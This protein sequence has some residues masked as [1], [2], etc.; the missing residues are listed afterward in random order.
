LKNATPVGRIFYETLAT[1]GPVQFFVNPIGFYPSL[2]HFFVKRIKVYPNRIN[3]LPGRIEFYPN[4]IG[5]FTNRIES[6]NQ[7]PEF[8]L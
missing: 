8:R 1:T 6:G 7:Y 5:F 4:R 2:L 3:F